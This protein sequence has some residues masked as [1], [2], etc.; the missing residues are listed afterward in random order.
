[1]HPPVNPDVT[2]RFNKR[3]EP[4]NDGPSAAATVREAQGLADISPDEQLEPTANMKAKQKGGSGT[5]K[6]R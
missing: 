6:T 3:V 4:V 5:M 1:M 2:N